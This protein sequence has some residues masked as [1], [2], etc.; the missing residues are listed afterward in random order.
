MRAIDRAS[1]VL[2]V[3]DAT[4]GLTD[5][6][7][8]VAGYAVERGCAMVVLL[9]KWDLIKGPERKAEIRDLIKDRLTFVGYAPVLAISA[10]TGKN[11]VRIWGSVDQ[12]YAHYSKTIS[13]SRLNAWLAEVRD[14]GHTISKGKKILRMK[15]MTQTSTCPPRFTVFANHP[16]IV[17]DSF[18]R[19]LE[20][21]LRG[22]FDLTG[23]PISFSFKRK[24]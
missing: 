11:V 6:D 17:D 20:N 19:F 9:N 23:T 8:R 5:Q 15:Y 7:Q 14:F 12:A 3:I 10:L 24:D 16:E 13:T 22:S 21:R 2:L 1:V 4:L 18:E